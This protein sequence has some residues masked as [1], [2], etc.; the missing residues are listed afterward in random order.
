M[1]RENRGG[2]AEENYL[3]DLKGLEKGTDALKVVST[4]GWTGSVL[5]L[6]M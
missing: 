3:L 1:V 4:E 6:V 5:A 2:G